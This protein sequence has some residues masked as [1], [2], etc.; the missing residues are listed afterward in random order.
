MSATKSRS[1]D[2]S[3]LGLLRLGLWVGLTVGIGELALLGLM[4]F[5][6]DRYLYYVSPQIVWMLPL[7]DLVIFGALGAF[8]EVARRVR[9][10]WVPLSMAVWVLSFGG[11]TALAYFFDERVHDIAL[12]SLAAGAAAQA[13]RLA[14]AHTLGLKTLIRR[15][16][17][18][19]AAGLAIAAVVAESRGPLRERAAL[20]ELAPPK[21]EAPNVLLIIWDTVRSHDVSAYGYERATTPALDRLATSGARFAHAISTASWTLPS[22]ASMFTGHYPRDLS[23]NYTTPLDDAEPTLAEALRER[24]YVTG[25]F[26]ANFGAAGWESG[27]ARG[28]IRY[29][30]FPRSVGQVFTSARLVRTALK[31]PAFRKLV[32]FHDVLGR[33]AAPTVGRDFLDWQTENENR[34]F[35]AFLNYYDAHAPYLPPADYATRYGEARPHRDPLLIERMNEP[36]EW[37]P[38][39]LQGELDAYDGAIAYLDAE[40]GEL[41]DE[42]DRR[43]VLDNTLVIVSSDHGEGF[44]EHDFLGHGDYVFGPLIQVPLVLAMPGGVPAGLTIEQPVS[45][46]NLPQTVLDLVGVDTT[47][48]F[49]GFSLA[50][51]WED[52]TPA[53]E[54]H[55]DAWLEAQGEPVYS[56]QD[57]FVSI[58]LGRYHYIADDDGNEQLFN[59]VGDPLQQANLAGSSDLFDILEYFRIVRYSGAETAVSAPSKRALASR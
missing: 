43:G 40:L 39:L 31:L 32:G 56:D 53:V 12:L 27:I 46:R 37:T 33:K 47:S 54:D 18:V 5:V 13:A 49:P 29:Q 45:L 52:P 9:P 41:L 28:F 24:G 20:A 19:L 35:F 1:G 23:A 21:A 58:V 55:P 4:E 6:L 30:D 42:L 11:F 15:T 10:A 44:G 3:P 38:E 51:F 26:V 48:R 34:P 16:A 7:A 59:I 8:L 25:G 50:R 22:H 2:A 36:S 57:G 17:P 14:G